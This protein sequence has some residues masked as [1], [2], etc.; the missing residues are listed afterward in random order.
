MSVAKIAPSLLSADFAALGVEVSKLEQGGAEIIHIDVMDGHFV[1]N[2]TFGAQVVKALRLRTRLTLDVHLMI[3]HPE[4]LLADFLAAGADIITV[5]A[6]T[7]R[8]LPRLLSEIRKGGAK[9]GVAF[10]PATP[11]GSLKYVL[12]QTDLVLIMTVNPGFG[13]QTFMPELLPKL[14]DCRAML[15][16][17]NPA[18]LL[19]V[20]GGINLETAP[21]VCAVGAD[22]LVCGQAVFG[23]G[24]PVSALA[25][26]G[27]VL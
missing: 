2:L 13:G 3:E 20:D 23:G 21:L 1:P 24:D 5:H 15:T 9:A 17:L 16:R 26:L 4:N 8:H 27:R 7:T 22:I 19:E 11:L 12:G 14:K 6:E 10:N 18:C 25:A